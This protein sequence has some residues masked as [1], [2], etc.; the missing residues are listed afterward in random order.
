MGGGCGPFRGLQGGLTAR[1]NSTFGFSPLP[2]FDEKPGIFNDSGPFLI[3]CP[4]GIRTPTYRSRDGYSESRNP[5]N[6][7]T[8]ASFRDMLRGRIGIQP[9]GI[10]RNVSENPAPC[11]TGDELAQLAAVWP[12]LPANVRAAVRLLVGL[13]SPGKPGG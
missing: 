4:P 2:F 6:N 7:N 11:S 5:L 3:G 12:T 10:H 1:I 13:D 9:G 8:V